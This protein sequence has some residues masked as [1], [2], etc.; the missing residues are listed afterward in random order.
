MIFVVLLMPIFGA[1]FANTVLLGFIL[2]IESKKAKVLVLLSIFLLLLIYLILS[3]SLLIT[4][5]GIWIGL[6][7]LIDIW[8]VLQTPKEEQ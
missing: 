6:A 4:L 3:K 5:F 2:S 8:T 1:V 7:F